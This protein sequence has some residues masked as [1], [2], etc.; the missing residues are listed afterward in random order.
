TLCA[1]M[2]GIDYR[3]FDRRRDQQDAV[4]HAVRDGF[5]SQPDRHVPG[6][7]RTG[8]DSAILNAG[9]LFGMD[10]LD[11]ASLSAGYR[12]GRRLVSEYTQFFRKYL[13]GCEDVATMATAT[14]MG[15]RESRRI[16]GEYELSW[17]EFDSRRTFP[18]QIAIYCKQVDVHV[19]APTDDEY[20][21]VFRDFDDRG[22][23]A[24]GEYYGIPYG[25]LVPRRWENLWAAGRCVSTDVKVNGSL[26]DQPGCMLLGQAAGTAA[27]QH[28]RTGEPGHDLNTRTL[29]E[30]LRADGAKLPQAQLSE[31]MIRT[32][33]DDPRSS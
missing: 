8:P 22:R 7:F 26:R 11:N 21:R 25:V 29:V 30:S 12:W 5:F 16:V 4:D 20:E 32:P 28:V 1:R 33:S 14:L 6:L 3:R 24:D 19:Y 2:T 23:P 31:S 13:D 10:A 17:A 27:V 18:D 9:H 15:V